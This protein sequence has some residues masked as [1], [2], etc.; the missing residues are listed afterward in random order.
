MD[1]FTV[2]LTDIGISKSINQDSICTKVILSDGKKASFSIVCDGMGGLSEGEVASHSVLNS[3]LRWVDNILPM[4]LKDGF[5]F[6]KLQEQWSK[7]IFNQ[8]PCL[9]EYGAKKGIRLG[10][11]DRFVY[12]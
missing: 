3:F 4:L 11:T 2:S 5:D 12:F 10:T 9:A 8:N 6:E 7:I 1:F